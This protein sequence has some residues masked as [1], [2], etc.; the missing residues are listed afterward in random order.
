MTFYQKRGAAAFGGKFQVKL[1]F[2]ANA[3]A[4]FSFFESFAACRSMS[5]SVQGHCHGIVTPVFRCVFCVRS[6]SRFS[7]G[8]LPWR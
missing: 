5:V 4:P 1:K 2:Q 7:A 6:K 8:A 3:A